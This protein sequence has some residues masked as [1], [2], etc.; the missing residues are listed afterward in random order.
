MGGGV[1]PERAGKEV[2]VVEIVI[3]PPVVGK[4]GVLGF[5]RVLLRVERGNPGAIGLV[6]KA[7]GNREPGSWPSPLSNREQDK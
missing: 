2:A 5:E 6:G 1:R 7:E 3:D 4:Q